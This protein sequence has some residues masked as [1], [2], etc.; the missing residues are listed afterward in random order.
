MKLWKMNLDRKYSC[1]F[2]EYQNNDEDIQNQ[3]IHIYIS[4]N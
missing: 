1:D 4:I 2:E 3:E